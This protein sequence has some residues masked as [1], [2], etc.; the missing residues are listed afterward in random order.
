MLFASSRMNGGIWSQSWP[1]CRIY[2]AAYVTIIP[3]TP[4][5]SATGFLEPRKLLKPMYQLPYLCPAGSLGSIILFY[6]VFAS[7]DDHPIQTRAWTLQ[8]EILSTR[9]ITFGIDLMWWSCNHGVKSDGG[10]CHQVT[11]GDRR[12]SGDFTKTMKE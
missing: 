11:P 7:N 12:L 5:S 1:A 3:A 9:V 2:K 6:K 10:H 8:E 4:E